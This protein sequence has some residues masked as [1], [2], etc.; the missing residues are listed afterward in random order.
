[1]RTRNV[2]ILGAGIAGLSAAFKLKEAGVPFELYEKNPKPGGLLDCFTVKGFRFDQAVHLSFA[3]E[4]EVREIFDKTP[5]YVHKP[6]ARCFDAGVWLR[7]PVQNNLYPLQVEE[8]VDLI[9]GFVNRPE[10]EI[11]NYGDW[12]DFQYGYKISNRFP[13]KYTQKYWGVEPEALGVDWVGNRMHRAS[14]E[15][16]LEGAMTEQVPNYYYTKEMRYPKQGGY[17]SFLNPLLNSVVPV[18]GV[19]FSGIDLDK[20]QIYFADGSMK[21]YTHLINTTPLPEFVS[22]IK[23]CPDNVQSISRKLQWTR[24]HLVS[25]GFSRSGLI[26]DLWSYIYD[27]DIL[28]S[29]MYSPSIKSSDNCPSG[30]SSVQFEIYESNL[31]QASLSKNDLLDNCIYALEKMN[32]SNRD[33]ICVSDVR[34]LA[35]G[36]VTFY[37][38]M[39]QDRKEITDW[40]SGQGVVLAGRFGCWDYLWSNQAMMSGFK[41]VESIV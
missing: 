21:T 5:Y 32:I 24:V 7:H 17:I 19:E 36:N 13:R 4:S 3:S 27:G 34:T 28:A 15:Q 18:C 16:V 38:G 9:S 35:Y 29:R 8:K 37:K 40:L 10:I 41:S 26:K 14:L 25:I 2:I 33:D 22:K 20:K 1:M 12:L 11:N 23:S 39:E 6:E 31:S 30:C